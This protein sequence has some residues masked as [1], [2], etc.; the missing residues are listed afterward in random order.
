MAAGI[1][2]PLSDRLF[3]RPEGQAPTELFESAM[4]SLKSKGVLGKPLLSRVQIVN[5][6]LLKKGQN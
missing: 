5:Q 3:M 4:G 6:S 1:F 2:M